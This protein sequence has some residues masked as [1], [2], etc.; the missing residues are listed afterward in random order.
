M[1]VLISG[2]LLFLLPGSGPSKSGK[3]ENKLISGRF[4]SSSRNTRL[5]GSYNTE[6]QCMIAEK[7]S[8]IVL[9]RQDFCDFK[10]RP[11]QL[12]INE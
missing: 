7:R 9:Q 10:F 12:Y 11:D 3:P 8:N 2:S 1:G 6:L 4:R 5:V